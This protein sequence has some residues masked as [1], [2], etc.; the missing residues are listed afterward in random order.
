MRNHQA[1]A[2]AA[3]DADH[4]RGAG[5]DPVQLGHVDPGGVQIAAAAP[6]HL[7]RVLQGEAAFVHQKTHQLR[8]G[9]GIV[10]VIKALRQGRERHPAL[11]TGTGS[12]IHGSRRL[13]ILPDQ[14]RAVGLV[15][16]FDQH[17][18]PA[19]GIPASVPPDGRNGAPVVIDDGERI[20]LRPVLLVASPE[21]DGIFSRMCPFPDGTG[22]HSIHK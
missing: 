13:K 22:H 21:P 7:E 1:A 17:V 14:R 6:R 11:L 19:D 5:L 20:V 12:G 4:V 3:Q 15:Q 10:R 18:V 2:A 8:R 16:E 9:D